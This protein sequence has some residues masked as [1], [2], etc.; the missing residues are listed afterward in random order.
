LAKVA[1]DE[2]IAELCL[3]IPSLVEH[4]GLH[5]NVGYGTK[6]HMDGIKQHGITQWHRKSYKPCSM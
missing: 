3:E 1:R 4:Y 5:T 6:K 2:Y